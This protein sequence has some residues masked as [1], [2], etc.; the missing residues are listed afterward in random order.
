[1]ALLIHF[2]LKRIFYIRGIRISWCNKFFTHVICF[3]IKILISH[4]YNLLVIKWQNDIQIVKT[5][6][7]GHFH[8]GS[9]YL[10]NSVESV[11]ENDVTFWLCCHLFP[12]MHF[13]NCDSNVS[14][15]AQFAVWISTSLMEGIVTVTPL[16]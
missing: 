7:L 5:Y 14:T 2:L 15:C 1:M 9:D 13:A 12:Y 6:P 3:Y 11:G 16:L 8:H 10:R 4:S